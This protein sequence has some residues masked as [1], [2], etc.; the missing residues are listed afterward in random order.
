VDVAF[1]WAIGIVVNV[2]VGKKKMVLV[3]KSFYCK[4]TTALN[5]I[6]RRH[7]VSPR[8]KCRKEAERF[9][10]ECP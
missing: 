3:K 10:R 6:F 7:Q 8:K 5:N 1:E 4:A 2:Q 9:L